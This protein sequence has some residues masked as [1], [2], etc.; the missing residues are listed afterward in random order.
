VACRSGLGKPNRLPAL[1]WHTDALG[2]NGRL[3]DLL[4]PASPIAAQRAAAVIA[5]AA[6]QIAANP[7]IGS[8]RAE[9]HE[10]P[11]RFGRSAYILRYAQLP[12]RE[13]LITRVWHSRKFREG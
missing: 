3:Y 6:S 11:A 4:A 9:F 2:D 5:A 1:I 13:V 8:N 10:W 12:N 7:L